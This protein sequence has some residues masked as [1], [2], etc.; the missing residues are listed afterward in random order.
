M[1]PLEDSSRWWTVALYRARGRVVKRQR[2]S[3]KNEARALQ[4]DWEAKHDHT[5]HA[6]IYQTGAPDG[7]R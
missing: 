5:Y 3:S 6:Q 7:P 4:R 1:S 2:C